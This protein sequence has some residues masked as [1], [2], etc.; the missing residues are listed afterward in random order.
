M[1]HFHTCNKLLPHAILMPHEVTNKLLMEEA[2]IYC[3]VLVQLSYS[4]I[5][6]YSGM[7]NSEDPTIEIWRPENTVVKHGRN[8][9]RFQIFTS[10]LLIVHF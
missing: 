3:D 10:L 9:K 8:A 1:F 5:H 7:L 6:G 2:N 4:I